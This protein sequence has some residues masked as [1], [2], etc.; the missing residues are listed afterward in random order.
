[1]GIHLMEPVKIV[2]PLF[3]R[4]IANPVKQLFKNSIY[5]T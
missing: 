3:N 1:M 2:E 5:N 4:V